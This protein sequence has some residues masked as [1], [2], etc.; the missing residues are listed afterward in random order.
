MHFLLRLLAYVQICKEFIYKYADRVRRSWFLPS[1][2]RDMFLLKDGAWID[3]SPNIPQ[4]YVRMRYDVE[5]HT[6][7][8]I[9]GPDPKRTTRSPWLSVIA[10]GRDLSDFFSTLRISSGASLSEHERL[11]LFAHQKGWFPMQPLSVTLRDGSLEEICLFGR[12]VN[13]FSMPNIDYIR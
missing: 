5:A 2:G 4:S 8:S 10:D 9:I 7:F 1:G 6:V 11:M 3:A 13:G 12:P